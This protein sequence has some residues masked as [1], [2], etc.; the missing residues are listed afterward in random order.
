MLHFLIVF[1][2]P[3]EKAIVTESGIIFDGSMRI[4]KP[5]R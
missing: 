5:A 3:H 4:Y 1:A 2:I